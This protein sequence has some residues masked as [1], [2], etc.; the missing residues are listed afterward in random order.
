MSSAPNR[1]DT[2][3]EV[4][5]PPSL[6][7][8]LLDA[9]PKSVWSDPQLT[10]LDPCAGQGNFLDEILPRLLAGLARHFPDDA[11]GCRR[12][13][14][15]H[16]VVQ[17]EKNPTNVR[18]LRAKYGARA[19][20]V[21][22][23]FLEFVGTGAGTTYDIILANPPYQAPKTATYTGSAGNRTLWDQFIVHALKLATPTTGILGFITPANWRR[24]GHPLWTELRERLLYLHIYGKPAGMDLF[25][26]QTRFDLFVFRAAGAPPL[27]T[28]PMVIDEQGATHRGT[29]RPRDW[30]FFPNYQYKSIRPLLVGPGTPPGIPVIHDASTYD[31]RKLTRR[32]TRAHPYPVIHT[33]TQKGMGLRYAAERDPRHFGV[34]KIVLNVNERQY[35]VNDWRGQYGMSQLSFGL[36]VRSRAEGERWMACLQSPEFDE[37]LS[38]TKWASFQTDYRMFTYFRRDMC[39]RWGGPRARATAKHRA[40]GARRTA[41]THVKNKPE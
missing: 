7:H 27:A 10:W 6:I 24:P 26:V 19:S 31:A 22:G 39:Q 16:M 28:L 5:T 4:F 21:A 35:P 29:L 14:L 23:D 11:A 17:V 34:G 3:G 33:L 13:I 8:E 25:G 40:P 36:P 2:Y 1:T 9:L 12:H 30:P 20:I 15:E 37:I 18:E 32:P 41:K 38:A